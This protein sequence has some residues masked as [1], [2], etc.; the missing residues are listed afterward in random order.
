LVKIISLGHVIQEFT[1]M[2]SIMR[3]DSRSLK[4]THILYSSRTKNKIK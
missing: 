2:K 3:N 1:N 4:N